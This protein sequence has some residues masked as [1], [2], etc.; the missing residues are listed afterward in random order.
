MRDYH[1]KGCITTH[2]SAAALREVIDAMKFDANQHRAEL[3]GA[4]R[5][6]A[7]Q[8]QGGRASLAAT[9]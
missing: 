1:G 8:T 3:A 7:W 9:S 4:S 6:A 2:Y 5:N